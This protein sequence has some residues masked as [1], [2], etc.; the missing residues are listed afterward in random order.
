MP[1]LQ[2]PRLVARQR[3]P[4]SLPGVC[5]QDGRT[6]GSLDA[7]DRASTEDSRPM[8]D[9]P[10][11]TDRPLPPYTF[12]PGKTPHPHSDPAGHRFHPPSFTVPDARWRECLAYVHG[13]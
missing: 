4:A 6:R 9:I 7:T 3:R 11:L 13:I 8:S 10:R 2:A 5:E 1:G 12:V